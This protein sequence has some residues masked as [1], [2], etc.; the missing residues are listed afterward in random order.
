MAIEYDPQ[1]VIIKKVDRTYR[2]VCSC[3]A[4]APVNARSVAWERGEA[5][6]DADGVCIDEKQAG[7]VERSFSQI[8]DDVIEAAGISATCAQI[9]ALI[10]AAGDKY[11]AEDLEKAKQVD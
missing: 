2:V 1:T 11:R 5:T 10:S 3:P 8:A 7:S 6:Y 9:M 4:H